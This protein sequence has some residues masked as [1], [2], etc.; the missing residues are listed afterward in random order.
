[1][2]EIFLLDM[3]DTLLDFLRAERANLKNTLAAFGIEGN[4]E[5]L[6]RYHDI[7]DALWKALERG[8]IV[9]EELKRRRFYALFSEF[10]LTVD[11][12]A[13]AKAYE[14]GFPEI[15]FPFAGAKE[16]LRALKARGRV[17]LCTN[18]STHIQKR[19][20]ALAGFSEFL[21][22]AFIS[23]E[24]GAD[25]PSFAYAEYVASHIRNYR[26]EEAVY[27]GDSLT[28]DMRCAQLLRADFVLFA[29][30]GIPEGYIGR[31][32]RD[33]ESALSLML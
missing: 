22:G 4:E 3:D 21:D 7:N 29:P 15:C 31:A 16:F 28:S 27:L 2:K 24:V 9:R 8:E 30:R 19:H 20:I 6:S 23:E 25:K 18:G 10:G 32:A 1:M 26:G 14:L 12:P 13:V 33:Y 17:Y 11:V 5:M